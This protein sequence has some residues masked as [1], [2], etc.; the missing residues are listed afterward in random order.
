MNLYIVIYE[1]KK[2]TSWDYWHADNETIAKAHG[3]KCGAVLEVALVT[4][5]WAALVDDGSLVEIPIA[6]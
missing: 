2:G 4:K 3:E 5:A 1:T 6:G